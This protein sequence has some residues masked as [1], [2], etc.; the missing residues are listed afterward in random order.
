MD[1]DRA[2]ATDGRLATVG[3]RWRFHGVRWLLL[4]VVAFVTHLAFPTPDIIQIPSYSVGATADRTVVSPISFVVRKTEEEISREGEERALA[5]R[6]VYRFDAQARDSAVAALRRF[7]QLVDAAAPSGATII[8]RAGETRSVSLS[9]DEAQW[10]S[11]LANR[12]KVAD[13]VTN[14]VDG[15]LSA[16]IADAGTVRAER[17]EVIVLLREGQER[18]VP[19]SAL[20]TFSDYVERSDRAAV[21]ADDA[22]G[23]RVFRRIA[24]SFFRP[25]IVFDADLTASRRGQLRLNV[26]SLRFRV[27]AGEQV[28]EA[29]DGVTV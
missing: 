3:A 11:E 1:R 19:R 9:A 21:P 22:L 12:R 7:L 5:V 4:L 28:V 15:L 10:L 25:T 18:L 29:G 16:G 20:I 17:S 2:P 8:A 26:D 14:F 6:P 27:A 13:S 24:A 23:Q